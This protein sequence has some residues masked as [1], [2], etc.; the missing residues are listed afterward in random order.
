[1]KFALVN[2]RVVVLMEKLY[3]VFDGDNVIKLGLVNPINDRGQRGTLAAARRPGHQHDS[4][5]QFNDVAQLLRQVEI[6]EARRPWRN[7]AHDD[8]MRAA[9]L[10]DIDAEAA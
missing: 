4:V 8:R 10:E 1:M 2:R 6:F 7:Y 5:F 9:L 3:R